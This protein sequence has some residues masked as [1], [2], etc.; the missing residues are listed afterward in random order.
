[1]QRTPDLQDEADLDTLIPLMNANYADIIL[2]EGFKNAAIP[3]IE[4]HRP[5][6][7][8]PLL[9]IDDASIIAVAS[10]APIELESSVPLPVL[11]LNNTEEISDFILK[12]IAK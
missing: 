6:L 3:K 5:S 9:C 2:V 10:D 12:F 11:D 7:G 8:K 4:V 1:M